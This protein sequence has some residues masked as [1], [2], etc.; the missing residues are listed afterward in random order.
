MFWAH[1]CS[2][3]SAGPQLW[4]NTLIHN[5][6]TACSGEVLLQ[7]K[8]HKYIRKKGGKQRSLFFLAKLCIIDLIPLVAAAF[9]LPFQRAALFCSAVDASQISSLVK[10]AFVQVPHKNDWFG[11]YQESLA[12]LHYEKELH[13]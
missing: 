9:R 7:K 3:L 1:Y 11:F 2:N 13:L 10:Q 5:E 4:H 6:G 8:V 12:L